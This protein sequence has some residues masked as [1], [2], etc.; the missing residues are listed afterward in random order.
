[1]TAAAVGPIPGSHRA[2][3]PHQRKGPD[4]RRSARRPQQCRCSRRRSGQHPGQQE[5]VMI[6]E[7]AQPK[8]RE[9][10][11][12]LTD[13]FRIRDRANSAKALGSRSPATA[14]PSSPGRNPEDVGGHHRQLEAG[15]L[16]QLLHTLLLRGPDPDQVDPVRVRSR[17]RRMSA[18]G[19]KLGRSICRSATLHS[20]TAS[21][22]SVFGR[23]GRC[24][25]SLALPATDPNRGPRTGRT[26]AASNR[27]S[28][29]SPPARR[30]APPT[31]WPAHITK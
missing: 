18:G 23:P 17:S 21:S 15:I 28:P 27:W 12:Q 5:P 31:G 13:L 19:T 4:G 22:R 1:M 24:L 8:P 9:R 10:L 2:G 7:G 14:P 29:P 16:E 3:R 30:R 25:T 11:L 20:H 6:I 26:A